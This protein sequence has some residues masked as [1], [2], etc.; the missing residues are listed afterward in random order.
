MQSIATSYQLSLGPSFFC[1]RRL[2]PSSL[3]WQIARKLV[4]ESAREKRRVFA[5]KN[6]EYVPK[7][8]SWRNSLTNLTFKMSAA[9]AAYFLPAIS[10][11]STR[12][13]VFK[14]QDNE[15]KSF[16]WCQQQGPGEKERKCGKHLLLCLHLPFSK[17]H[18]KWK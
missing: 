8:A 16:K 11:L 6:I 3:L 15:K 14:C 2:S 10:S 7:E 5:K 13:L 9:T 1:C 17:Y 12:Q 4:L 18:L